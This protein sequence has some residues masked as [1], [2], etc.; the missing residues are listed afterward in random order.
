MVKKD[1]ISR[2]Q[3]ELSNEQLSELPNYTFFM[4]TE[5]GYKILKK[6]SYIV[7]GHKHFD[8]Y[9]TPLTMYDNYNELRSL[10]G[11]RYLSGDIAWT[12]YNEIELNEQIKILNNKS[13]NYGTLRNINMKQAFQ[14]KR[15]NHNKDALVNLFN[16]VIIDFC[17]VQYRIIVKNLY[18]EIVK[19]RNDLKLNS[20]EFGELV[21]KTTTYVSRYL[22]LNDIYDL[23]EILTAYL[24]NDQETISKYE[25][26]IK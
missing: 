9:I 22:E 14:L 13:N 24:E 4:S 11:S 15:E 8:D 3:N 25:K 26:Y 16:V 19:L 2:I 18:K 5:D 1:L 6:Y 7:Y 17:E 10:T 23:Y 20:D 12:I 21:D